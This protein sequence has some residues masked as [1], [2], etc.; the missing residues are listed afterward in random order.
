MSLE[1]VE[2]AVIEENRVVIL[3]N[4]LSFE[5]DFKCKAIFEGR[6]GPYNRVLK[7]I[8]YFPLESTRSLPQLCKHAV[9]SAQYKTPVRHNLTQA[10]ALKHV[11][12]ELA[13][14]Y[15]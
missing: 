2:E 4:I 8:W 15:L 1:P 14:P 5:F 9:V 12:P 13:K 6:A 7:L 10:R 11:D 3:L